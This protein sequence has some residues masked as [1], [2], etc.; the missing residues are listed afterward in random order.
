VA[1]QE[2][3]QFLPAR[4]TPINGSICDQ[5]NRASHPYAFDPEKAGAMLD[6]AGYPLKDGKRFS[7]EFTYMA[8]SPFYHRRYFCCAGEAK[9][10]GHA[11]G[12][13]SPS[14]TRRRGS[15]RAGEMILYLP[16]VL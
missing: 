16:L 11:L 4:L 1:L 10:R 8:V 3:R 5:Q 7:L 15:P 12:A 6:A 14:V 13:P 2:R 9:G